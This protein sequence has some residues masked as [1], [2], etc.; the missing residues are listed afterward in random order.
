MDNFTR[1]FLLVVGIEAGFSNDPDDPGNWTGGAKGV[2]MLKGTKY[3]ISAKAYP[4]LDIDNLTLA[5][6]ELLYRR[7]Y[8]SAVSGD[9]LPWPLVLLVFDCAVNQGQVTARIMLQQA[10]G[11]VVDGKLGPITIAACRAATSWHSAHFMTLRARRYMS[12]PGF[13]HDGDGWFTRLFTLCLRQA[14]GE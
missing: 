7:D 2:G 3:G 12:L 9:A 11:V 4:T 1:A 6:A 14:Q 5:D 10:L 13:A 8:W